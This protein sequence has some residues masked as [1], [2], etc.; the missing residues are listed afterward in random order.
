MS[1][2]RL[3]SDL[4]LS[5]SEVHASLKRGRLSGLFAHNE[6]KRVN[7]SALLE[8]LEHGLRYAFPADGTHG[9]S[10]QRCLRQR[11]LTLSNSFQISLFSRTL[12][13][14]PIGVESWFSMECLADQVAV[15]RHDCLFYLAMLS[16]RICARSP[17]IEY[18]SPFLFRPRFSV[19]SL[20]F[21]YAYGHEPKAT[22]VPKPFCV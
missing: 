16:L 5:S 12:N 3:A 22:P 20:A 11:P 14:F 19:S 9:G 4:H 13:P 8:F 1:F 18:R 17:T 6:P 2:Q 10:G 7:R 21:W 15:S